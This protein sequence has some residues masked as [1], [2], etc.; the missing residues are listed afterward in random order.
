MSKNLSNTF[1]HLNNETGKPLDDYVNL[2]DAKEM[3]DN[4]ESIDQIE[5]LR[6]YTTKLICG[7]EK[8]IQRYPD[9]YY[10]VVKPLYETE[11]SDELA[12]KF[13]EETQATVLSEILPLLDKKYLEKF[14]DIFKRK[15]ELENLKKKL[16]QII[17]RE[18]EKNSVREKELE[19]ELKNFGKKNTTK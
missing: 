11:L 4:P 2:P 19:E 7:N 10:S 12:K 16:N 8:L 18:T 9:K 3:L 13:L 15:K 5:H 17:D 1:F 6:Q 14:L